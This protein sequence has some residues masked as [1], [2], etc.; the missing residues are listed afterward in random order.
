MREGINLLTER[1]KE[2]LRLLLGGHDAKS[3]AGHLGLSIHT[4][5]ERLRDA[6]RKLSVSS[7]REAARILGEAERHGPQS[8]GDKELGVSVGPLSGASIAATGQPSPRSNRM[9]WLS[10]GMLIM[11]ILI[12]AAVLAASTLNLAAP[13]TDAAAAAQAVA[14]DPAGQRVARQWLAIVDKGRWQDSW[15]NAGASFR[16]AVTADRWA[17]QVRPVREPL[18]AVT[19]RGLLRATTTD[20]L[21]GAPAGEYQVVEFRTD[22]ANRTGAI[23][24]VIL[25]KEGGKWG[26]AGYFIK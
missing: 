24:T 10:G 13:A 22:F 6:R 4:I 8:V 7:S 17:S 21:P 19:S 23:E 15:A 25:M 2:A 26:V 9:L 5:N 11:S 16:G 3:I 14:T 20:A 18:G 1:E 12:A